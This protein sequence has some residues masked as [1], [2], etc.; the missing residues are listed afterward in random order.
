ML[1]LFLPQ[2]G[3]RHLRPGLARR[4]L[5][6]VDLPQCA[7]EGEGGEGGRHSTFLNTHNERNKES[8]FTGRAAGEAAVTAVEVRRARGCFY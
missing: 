6:G 7:G 2:P 5:L 1:S 8:V 4:L 3:P